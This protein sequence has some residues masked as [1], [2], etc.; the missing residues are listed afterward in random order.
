M[1]VKCVVEAWS[2]NENDGW[3]LP[4]KKMLAAKRCTR[5]N[6]GSNCK[7][8]ALQFSIVFGSLPVRFLQPSKFHF[9]AGV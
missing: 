6:P 9:T 3:D 2:D 4:R 1:T 7:E 8:P 5:F